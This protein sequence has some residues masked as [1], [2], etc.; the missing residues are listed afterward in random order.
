MKIC[1]DNRWKYFIVLKDDD[2]LNIHRSFEVAWGAMKENTKRVF[3][4]KKSEIEQNYRWENKIKYTDTKKTCI[5][6]LFWSVWK[7]NPENK[8]VNTSG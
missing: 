2:L 5:I 7:R 6:R 8:R 1:E 3:L 4:G